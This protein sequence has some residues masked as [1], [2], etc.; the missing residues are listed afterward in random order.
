M[1]P[2]TLSS[3]DLD[4]LRAA[5][6]AYDFDRREERDP[7]FPFVQWLAVRYG[8]T[9][10]HAKRCLREY[11]RYALLATVSERPL[12]P[13]EAVDFVWR[14]HMESGEHYWRE[15]GCRVLR[16]PLYRGPMREGSIAMRAQ[17]YLETRYAYARLFGHAPPSEIWPTHVPPSHTRGSR[18]RGEHASPLAGTWA[19]R[20]TSPAYRWL[21][22]QG[23][24]GAVLYGLATMAL[25][26]FFP[27]A[28]IGAVLFTALGCVVAHL[29]ARL[30]DRAI[31]ACRKPCALEPYALALL[32]GGAQR[33]VQLALVKLV[34]A[35]VLDF[36]LSVRHAVPPYAH[37]IEH[38]V[39][40]GLSERRAGGPD[41]KRLRRAITDHLAP[42]ERRLSQA[43]LVR[44][45]WHPLVCWTLFAG[46]AIGCS[47]PLLLRSDPRLDLS[48]L[49]GLFILT[50]MRL[51]RGRA[52]WRA[53]QVLAHHSERCAMPRFDAPEESRAWRTIACVGPSALH[54]TSMAPLQNQLCR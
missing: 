29:C 12:V 51:P 15:F 31:A 35:G 30:L 48:W 11:R 50:I 26:L 7:I 3:H 16:R 47:R 24:L 49:L 22:A 34:H 5:V 20:A 43:G 52:T 42:M 40:R 8:W 1:S 14:M 45:A 54:A 4:R 10:R 33:V 46:I 38:A 41:T 6:E 18:G 9:R 21:R 28:A 13:P 2:L 37:P 32:A 39:V 44:G 19:A 23:A 25:F 36:D 27:D 17:S 53:K